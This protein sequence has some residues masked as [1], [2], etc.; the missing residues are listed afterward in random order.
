MVN[1][2]FNKTNEPFCAD[3]DSAF[4]SNFASGLVIGPYRI[5]SEIKIIYGIS[6]S[7]CM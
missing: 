1:K 5:L 7:V 6:V 2:A 4:C 3:V